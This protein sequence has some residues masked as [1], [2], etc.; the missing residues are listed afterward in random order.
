MGMDLPQIILL[1]AIFAI[2]VILTVLGVQL[3][4]LLRDARDTLKKADHVIDNIDFLTTSLT[5]TSG[6]FSQLS[7]S[8]Q[9]GMQVV[10]MVSKLLSS[11]SKNSK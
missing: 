7:S 4:I 8:L 10:G 2:T 9:S 5:R 3:I 1:I 11:K 6:T